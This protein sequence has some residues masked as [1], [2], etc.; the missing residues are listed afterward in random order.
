AGFSLALACDFIIAAHNAVFVMAYTNVGLSPDGGSSWNLTRMLPRA[1]VMQMLMGGERQSAE[2]LLQLGVINATAEPAGA[3]GQALA[4]AERLNERAPNTM[5]SIKEL[6]NDAPTSALHTQL[7][8]EREHFVRNLH[9]ANAGEGI[10]AF[11]EKR[12]AK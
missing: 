1:T 5:A 6:V 7:A 4:L 12:A 11:M 2:R 3:F 9:H 8:A 10:A